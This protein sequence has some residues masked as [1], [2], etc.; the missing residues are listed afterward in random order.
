MNLWIDHNIFVKGTKLLRIW[1]IRI[2]CTERNQINMFAHSYNAGKGGTN[3]PLGH[4]ILKEKEKTKK[5]F[6]FYKK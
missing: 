2:L 1:L 4:W 5:K 3:P 6:C